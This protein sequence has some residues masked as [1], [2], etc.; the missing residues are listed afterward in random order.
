MDG[1]SWANCCCHGCAGLIRLDSGLGKTIL[2]YLP[3]GPLST[4]K[5]TTKF[6]H[7]NGRPSVLV[8]LEFGDVMV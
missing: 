4:K 5:I 7:A 3:I 6:A 2:S 1:D 8:H